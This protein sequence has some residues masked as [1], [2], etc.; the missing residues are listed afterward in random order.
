[1]CIHIY[2]YIYIH[3]FI[4]APNYVVCRLS[5]YHVLSCV[6]IICRH[7]SLMVLLLIMI[8]ITILLPRG[9]WP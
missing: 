2:I 6:F 5:C 7:C 3:V 1:M 9:P 4:Y 8:I